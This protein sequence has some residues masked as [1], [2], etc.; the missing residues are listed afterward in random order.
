MKAAIAAFV[1][2]A[3]ICLVVYS[4]ADP[5]LCSSGCGNL[6]EGL[7]ILAYKAFGPWGIR[8]LLCVFAC[9]AFVLAIKLAKDRE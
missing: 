1:C 8:A 2:V 9:L 3:L 7:F 4:F 5:T 6:T